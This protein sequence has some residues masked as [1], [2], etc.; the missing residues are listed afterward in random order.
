MYVSMYV[1][2]SVSLSACLP[3]WLS[4]CQS[5]MIGMIGAMKGPKA[6][7]EMRRGRGKRAHVGYPRSL[8]L[9]AR[10]LNP[11]PI[12]LKPPPLG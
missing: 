9:E 5:S 10:F 8:K 4:V 1:S 3:V 11:E 7:A 2:Q 6:C 12:N